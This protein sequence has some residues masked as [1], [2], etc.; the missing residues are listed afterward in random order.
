MDNY[1]EHKTNDVFIIINE[2]DTRDLDIRVLELGEK[3]PSTLKYEKSE[4]YGQDGYTKVSED[5]Y[6]GFER[7]SIVMVNNLT[8]YNEFIDTIYPGLDVTITYSD[9][10]GRSRF[11]TVQSIEDVV[12]IGDNRQITITVDL[13]PFQYAEPINEVFLEPAS[14][15]NIGN[16]YAVPYIEVVGNGHI[17]LVVNDK[18]MRLDVD[19]SIIID[20]VMYD[21]YDKNG[22]RANSR[23]LE[24]DF[25]RLKPG[26]NGIDFTG[27]V[28]EVNISVSWRWR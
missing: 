7:T 22:L 20:N 9:D 13:Q 23:R 16:V 18:V 25:I 10:S 4:A 21:V 8:A 6:R 17:E 2:L 27:D 12:I 19:E 1:C 5:A 3:Q 24:G 15:E 26:S 11:G 28:N 14:I